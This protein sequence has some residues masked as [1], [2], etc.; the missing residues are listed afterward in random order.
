V[1]LPHRD[2]RHFLLRLLP[3][4]S[5]GAEIGVWKGDFSAL[6][7]ARVRPRLLHLIDPWAFLDEEPYRVARYGGGLAK[8]QRDMDEI[9]EQVRRRFAKPLA[10]GVVRLHRSPSAEA[11]GSIEDGSLDWVY[12][13]GNHL[14][15]FVRRDL[16]LFSAKVKS[17]GL[18][19]GDDYGEAGWWEDGVSRAVDEF[20]VET[21]AEPVA[22]RRSQFVLRNP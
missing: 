2:R 12:I 1:S 7:L 18:I 10:T 9:Y 3:R 13:D 6:V 11:A 4:G 22:F 19:A 17:G 16:E 14:Y 5:A 21:G 15:E 8:G 20:V